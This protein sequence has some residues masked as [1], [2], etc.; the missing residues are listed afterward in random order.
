[1][2]GPTFLLLIVPW[3]PKSWNGLKHA[4]KILLRKEL[5]GATQHDLAELGWFE[6]KR[7]VCRAAFWLG[8]GWGR[9][10]GGFAAAGCGSDHGA[11]GLGL[12]G[13]DFRASHRRGICRARSNRHTPGYTACGDLGGGTQWL[14]DKHARNGYRKRGTGQRE[15]PG[16]ACRGRS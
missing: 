9:C 14:W 16:P 15:S 7:T 8:T 6:C 1:M 4:P 12:A 2:A 3:M 13:A 11:P 10:H 5:S